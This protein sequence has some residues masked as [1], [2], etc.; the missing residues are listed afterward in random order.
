MYPR[1]YGDWNGTDD[2]ENIAWNVGLLDDGM[3]SANDT[4][5]EDTSGS[6]CYDSC[7]GNCSRCS[8]STCVDDV[9][10]IKKLIEHIQNDYNIEKRAIF[11]TGA[12][13]GGMMTHYFAA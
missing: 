4:C 9:N 8:W 5:F 6:F 10:F 7:S 11:V 1:G 12:S 3:D 13:N 2:D